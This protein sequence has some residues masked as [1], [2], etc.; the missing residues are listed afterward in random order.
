NGTG[1]LMGVDAM[2]HA[3][4]ELGLHKVSSEVL[5][6]NEA[7]L[8]FQKKLGFQQEGLLREAHFDG[9]RHVDVLRLG[10]LRHEWQ[11]QR[12]AVARSKP[13]SQASTPGESY[14]IAT[15]KPWHEE[16]YQALT[17]TID[18]SWTLVRSR[19]EL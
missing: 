8:Y 15:C 14:I 11:K 13:P 3:F 16:G 7:S 17:R 19:E 4:M 6:G 12:P 5:A 18:A 9:E 2:D 1:T 10:I